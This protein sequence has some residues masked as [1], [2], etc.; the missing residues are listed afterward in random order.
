MSDDSNNP[1][2]SMDVDHHADVAGGAGNG[3]VGANAADSSAIPSSAAGGS[4]SA[5]GAHA[6]GSAGSARPAH[7]SSAMDT[8]AAPA[9]SSVTISTDAGASGSASS[10]SKHLTGPFARYSAKHPISGYSASGS[11]QGARE[12][13]SS[14]RADVAVPAGFDLAQAVAPYSGIT[15]VDRLI[16][17]AERCSS[18]SRSAFQLALDELLQTE[19]TT[20]YRFL[21]ER[22]ASVP[23]IRLDL[24]TI[25]AK[26]AQSVQQYERL[27][28]ELS[29]YKANL[30]KVRSRP[31]K[32]Y[33]PFLQGYW[34][35]CRSNQPFS[36]R[37][38]TL[39]TQPHAPNRRTIFSRSKP[40][41][42][43][44][45]ASLWPFSPSDPPLL[46]FL[47]SCRTTFACLLAKWETSTLLVE[48]TALL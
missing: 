18:L 47:S 31:F 45:S 39:S 35:L 5:S 25:D 40:R 12:K 17:I 46:V 9:K 29:S 27:E 32:P 28:L 37:H 24:A 6:S 3:Q 1:P 14:A 33:S 16:Y 38:S 13:S 11:G 22:L 10:S 30:I 2:T 15:V 48:T 42:I 44:L 23:G 41:H 19:N 21:A 26:Q 20:M 43:F 34:L 4:D 8:D 36:F 7:T